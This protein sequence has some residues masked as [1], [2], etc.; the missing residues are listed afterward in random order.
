VVHWRAMRDQACPMIPL[1]PEV[2][3]DVSDD[4]D[5]VV[6]RLRGRLSQRGTLRVRENIAQSLVDT[7]RVLI[8][9]SGLHCSQ[10]SLLTV[11]PA[12]LAGGG[13]GLQRGWFFSAPTLACT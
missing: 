1:L 10:T 4:L 3:V 7:G 2:V 12:A 5:C 9:L 11:F 6:L 8:D 13:A